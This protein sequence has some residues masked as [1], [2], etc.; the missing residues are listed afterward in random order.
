MAA[1]AATLSAVAG[2]VEIAEA[3]DRTRLRRETGARLRAAMA[4]RGID[5]LVLLGNDAVTYATGTSW[6]LGDA[7]LSHIDRPVAVVL[8]DDPWPHLFAPVRNAWESDLAADH[9]HPPAFLECDEGV[10]Q[11]ARGIAELIP[12]SAVVGVDECTG[13]MRRAQER[14]FAARRPVDAAQVVNAAK[15]TKTT[16]ELS[17][18]RTACR[19]TGRVMAEVRARLSPGVRQRDLSAHFLRR[20]FEF[21]ADAI[22]LEPVWQVMPGGRALSMTAGGRELSVGD[23][24]WSDASISY[25]GYCSAFGHTWLVGTDPTPR[26]Q[27]QFRQWQAVLSA[28]LDVTRAGVTAG[29]L[30]RV[31]TAANGGRRPWLPHGHLGHGLGV[32]AG[33]APMIGTDLG[34]EFD[35]NFVFEPGMVLVLEPRV[36]QDGTS[37]YRRK[38][39]VVITEDGFLSLT[40][41]PRTPYAY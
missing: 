35:E 24:V 39:V 32:T 10:D 8:A 7:G 3:P 4:E 36:W 9:L 18:I 19:I 29:D 26:Q 1:A 41:D 23:V 38:H 20:A 11:F 14:L 5:A 15:L 30:A 21:G 31:A 33:E 40:D 37:G 28:V 34:A 17:C 16:D 25:G 27:A 13:A 6:R 12:G 22:M 2:G